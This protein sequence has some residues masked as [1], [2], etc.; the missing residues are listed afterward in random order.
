[1]KEIK[2]LKTELYDVFVIDG[3]NCGE[4]CPQKYKEYTNYDY[5]YFDWYCKHFNMRLKNKND[6][7]LRCDRCINNLGEE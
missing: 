4:Q 7:R 3:I 5:G 2:L 1:M 6:K